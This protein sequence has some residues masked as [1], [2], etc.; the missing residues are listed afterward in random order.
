MIDT[1]ARHLAAVGEARR[2]IRLVLQNNAAFRA[3]EEASGAWPGEAPVPADLAQDPQF[4][5]YVHLTKALEALQPIPTAGCAAVQ[6]AQPLSERIG[7]V[8][9]ARAS[10]RPEEVAFE[11]AAPE[12]APNAD[13]DG[14][15][16]LRARLRY[17]LEGAP[18]E[19]QA[20]PVHWCATGEEAHVAIVRSRTYQSASGDAV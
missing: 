15:A 9:P 14:L 19:V 16:R 5:A 7:E 2:L 11:A 18:E 6:A 12:P 8:K 3:F 1:W 20:A 17:V 13:A 10:G 4:I